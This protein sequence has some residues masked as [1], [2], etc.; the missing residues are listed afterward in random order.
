MLSDEVIDAGA[1]FSTHG[2]DNMEI[3]TTPITGSL[4]HKDSLGWAG[5]CL[6]LDDETRQW[7][8]FFYNRR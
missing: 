2:H 7:L 8:I 6:L 3:V 4:A 1:D 5:N